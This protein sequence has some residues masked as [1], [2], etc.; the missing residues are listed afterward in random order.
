MLNLALKIDHGIDI[1]LTLHHSRTVIAESRFGRVESQMVVFLVGKRFKGIVSLQSVFF[2]FK[3]GVR[4][5]QSP[6]YPCKFRLSG[7]RSLF[8]PVF[9]LPGGD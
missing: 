7:W 6:L 3:N 5:H 4:A 1:G 2:L 9:K 8:E